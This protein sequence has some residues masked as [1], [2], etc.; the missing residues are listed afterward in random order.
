MLP[1]YADCPRRAAAKQFYELVYDKGYS[2]KPSRKSIGAVIG[3]SVHAAAGYAARSFIDTGK[4]ADIKTSLECSMQKYKTEC[5]YQVD[6][7]NTTRSATDSEK[8]LKTLVN[9]LYIEVLPKVTPKYS[10]LKL[11]AQITTEIQFTGSFDFYNTDLLLDD[12]KCGSRDRSY[13]SQLGGY[14]LLAMSNGFDRPAGY[15]IWHLPRTAISK[16][17]SGAQLT[18]YDADTCTNSAMYALRQIEKDVNRFVKTGN[19]WEFPANPMSQMCSEKYCSAYG[20]DF[21]SLGKGC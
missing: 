16:S 5:E 13:H 12:L 9:S 20:T 17:Y 1:A 18:I 8:Q 15:R 10:E 11:A 21:C 4:W 6:Y 14:G 7:D 3:I 19:C 2:L